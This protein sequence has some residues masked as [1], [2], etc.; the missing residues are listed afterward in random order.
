MKSE[1]TTPEYQN[2][3]QIRFYCNFIVS[4]KVPLASMHFASFLLAIQECCGW[5][6][7]WKIKFNF[8]WFFFVVDLHILRVWMTLTRHCITSRN[9]Q[10]MCLW[11]FH[12]II[13]YI[14]GEKGF[15]WNFKF[16]VQTICFWFTELDEHGMQEMISSYHHT[17]W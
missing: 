14:N 11:L 16:T 13:L 6:K 5:L 12:S 15:I 9:R 8:Y 2:F 4:T 1:K 3:Y 7:K 10:T 17:I